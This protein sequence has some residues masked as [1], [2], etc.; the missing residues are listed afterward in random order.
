MTINIAKQIIDQRVNKILKENP[1]YFSED[2]QDR[3]FSK[4]FLLLGVAAYLKVDISEAMTY[5]T[6]GSADGGI[7]AVFKSTQGN[8]VNVIIFQSKYTRDLEK[9]AT[10]PVNAIEKSITTVRTVFDPHYK[11]TS[12]N[13]QTKSVVDE[14]HSLL[15]DGYIP[16]V[17]F[18]MV[19]NGEKWNA[20]GQSVIDN[21]FEQREQICFEHFGYDE[22]LGFIQQ[23][24]RIDTQLQLKGLAIQENFSYK[25]VILGKVNITEIH[26]LMNQYG[27]LLLE[28]NIRR[29][30]GQNDI[31]EN[32]AKCLTDEKEKSNFFFY[33]NGITFICDKFS[34]NGL[35]KEDWIVKLEG[36]QI[37]NGGQ[38]CRT[39]LQTL[40][41]S[42]ALAVEDVFVLVRIYE[43]DKDEAIVGKI[44][45]ATNHQNPVDLRDLKSNDQLQLS[46][47]TSAEELGYTYK[48][49]RDDSPSTTKN[50]IPA[51]VAAES[52]FAVWRLCPHL[53]K[54]KKAEL[55]GGY[56][57]QIFTKT[58][59]AAQMIMAVVIFRYCDSMRK[60]TTDNKEIQLIRSYGN[61]F[62][63][64]LVGQK[65]Q[66]D[67][68]KELNK[69][70]HKNFDE[71]YRYFEE[72][73]SEL[74]AF[75]E[76]HLLKIVKSYF[77][78]NENISLTDVDGRTLAA[79]FR[80]FE[81]VENYIS[82]DKWWTKTV[83]TKN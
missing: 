6:D 37:I 29:Y 66:R 52:V 43:V 14:I 45:Y 30:L 16:Y 27:D 20:E 7:D 1:D 25:R 34:F 77:N 53:A 3:R 41:D 28:K 32:I 39:I 79:L 65:L 70:T 13:A 9:D 63:A 54:Y 24:K 40:K 33:N 56:Y 82:N 71:I 67:K 4:C 59:N 51:T 76:E 2:S 17:T 35:Q 48:R 61:Y 46:L 49:K 8:Q 69:L 57:D 62:L 11:T 60:R 10:F 31:N 55:F 23:K 21:A 18:V 78:Q 38:T 58:L 12:L 50:T 42:P 75:A 80:R 47:E 15:L 44:T 81:I 72:H 36:L 26:N 19:S 74:F 5:I 64:S 83:T 68:F 73:K 22:I